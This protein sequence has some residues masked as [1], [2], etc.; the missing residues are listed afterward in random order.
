MGQQIQVAQSLTDEATINET[1]VAKF[2]LLS[3]PWTFGSITP[4]PKPPGEQD[5]E[6]AI[7]FGR[8]FERLM[9][10]HVEEV[11]ESDGL[12]HVSLIGIFIEWERTK[13]LQRSGRVAGRYFLHTS[14]LNEAARRRGKIWKEAVAHTKSLMSFILRHIRRTYPKKSDGRFPI[15]AGP[16][17]VDRIDREKAVLY[18]GN[19]TTE[20][21]LVRNS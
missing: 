9:L 3:L 21:K 17:L 15:Y 10:D 7:L 14:S 1:L 13:R 5:V 20:V 16:D 2:D 8:Q 18:Y 19:E 4:Q 12:Y 11:H 6:I